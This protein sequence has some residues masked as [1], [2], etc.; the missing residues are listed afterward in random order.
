MEKRNI[1]LLNETLKIIDAGNYSLEGKVV[2]LKL[3]I[4]QMS[5]AIVLTDKE[6]KQMVDNPPDLKLFTMGR[7][8]T[9]ASNIDS[10][11]AA[12]NIS[13]DYSFQTDKSGCWKI[14]VLNFA[15][16]V[17]PG[18][19]VRRGAIAQEE[20]L[21]RKSTLLVSLESKDAGKYYKHNMKYYSFLSSD[22][23]ILSPAVEILRDEN[24]TLL[25]E[26]VVVSVLT[27]AAPDVKQRTHGVSNEEIEKVIFQRIMGML[28]VAVKYKYKYLVL[29]AWGCG[30]FGNDAE[31]VARLFY[32]AIKEIKCG[33]FTNLPSLFNRVDFAVLDHTEQ[34]YNLNSFKKYFDNFYRD[35]DEATRQAAIDRKKESEKWLDA[36]RGCLIGGAAGDALGY[37]IEF[38]NLDEIYNRYSREGITEYTLDSAT[39]K[40]LITDDTQ[41]TLFTATGILHGATRASLRGISGPVESY[42]YMAYLDWLSTQT[43]KPS[44]HNISWLSGVEELHAKRAPGHTCMRALQ[45]GQG[46]SIGE[47]IND[48]KGCGGVMRVAPIAL[49]FKQKPATLDG[50]NV[51]AIT[52]GHPLGYMPAAALVQ[53]IGRIV[54]GGCP[55]GDTLYDIVDEC[56]DVVKNLFGKDNAY[57]DDLLNLMELAVSLSRNSADD[58][59]NIARIGQG[60]VAEEALGVALYCSLKYYD[61]FSKAIIAAVNH[62]GDS[63]STGAITGNIVG[64]HIGYASIPQ[65]WKTDLEL[66]DV[67]LEVADDLCHDCQMSEYSSYVDEKWMQKY[68]VPGSFFINAMLRGVDLQ[69]SDE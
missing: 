26:T 32:K 27:C 50:A 53:I 21:C 3:N 58:T 68:G 56:C 2:K 63:D 66:H 44:K 48:S 1:E 62:D 36:I 15:N 61:D 8:R 39:G 28:Q 37:P 22:N 57:V 34:K 12:L 38:M 54:Y 69:P 33:Q 51:A 31:I 49:Y 67:I 59:Q 4:N 20:A 10:F 7:C 29:G 13:K 64:A 11:A 45:S 18:G 14:L 5:E 35:E 60:W 65:K 23:M 17:E 24:D 52:H 30:A 41:M 40:A 46:G 43:G 42:V 19:G 16:P 47:P 9:S 6:V 25:D 55:N